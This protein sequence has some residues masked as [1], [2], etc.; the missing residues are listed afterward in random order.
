MRTIIS[1]LAIAMPPAV[2]QPWLFYAPAMPSK[3][4]PPP[5]LPALNLLLSLSGGSALLFQAKHVKHTALFAQAV[6]LV[7]WP[8]VET[9]ADSIRIMYANLT[10][11]A[12]SL[13]AEDLDEA[14][15]LLAEAK[16]HLMHVRRNLA[17]ATDQWHNGTL[18]KATFAKITA[19]A[20]LAAAEYAGKVATA[21][22]TLSFVSAAAAAVDPAE[23]YATLSTPLA[24]IAS[25]L[26]LSTST[27]AAAVLHGCPLGADALRVLISQASRLAQ[28]MMP[29]ESSLRIEDALAPLAP[30]RRKW[31]RTALDAAAA[32]AGYVIARR[33]KAAAATLS[34]AALGAS[35]L[36]SAA[37]GLGGDALLLAAN[38]ALPEQFQQP[39]LGGDS[40]SESD[41]AEAWCEVA[42]QQ[43]RVLLVAAGLLYQLTSADRLPLLVRLIIWP[44]LLVEAWLAAL[45]DASAVGRAVSSPKPVTSSADRGADAAATTSRGLTKKVSSSRASASPG[46]GRKKAD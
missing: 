43:I 15:V 41:D 33:A 28:H 5:P 44:L 8:A 19:E 29:A 39:I 4:P 7:A 27:P 37:R 6:N 18:D 46:R 12:A 34:A 35:A 40:A 42:W 1:L 3:P 45:S 16:A 30:Q 9:A 14:Q 13:P 38:E 23:L 20:K 22:A 2:A 21:D 26:A 25:A 32:F 17:V 10:A 36:V 31:A 11:A 24:A